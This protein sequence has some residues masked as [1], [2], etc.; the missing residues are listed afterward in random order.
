MKREAGKPDRVAFS[1]HNSCYCQLPLVLLNLQTSMVDLTS[2]VSRLTFAGLSVF[3]RRSSVI[4]ACMLCL[5]SSAHS[6]EITITLPG[7]ET[8]EMVWI[9]PGTFRMGSPSSEPGR[10]ED[11]GPFHERFIS[12]GFYLGKYEVT[13]A[14]W[15]S[16]MEW[17]PWLGKD[18]KYVKEGPEIPA[19]CISWTDAQQFVD[20]MNAAEGRE[21]YRLPNE[22]E[23]E[24]A[25][26]AGTT[27]RWSFGEN[28]GLLKQHAWYFTPPDRPG[29]DRAQKVGMKRPNPWKLYDTHGNVWE[30]VQDKYG[31]NLTRIR[32]DST[33]PDTH[34]YRVLRGGAFS[35]LASSTRSASRYGY[36]PLGRISSVGFRILKEAE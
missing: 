18:E 22:A 9:A 21:V 1:M 32:A 27:T 4:L 16:V 36:D 14:Q 25:S 28:E 10:R 6:K 35:T 20:R 7:G 12:K 23:W 15:I 19:V 2:H 33:A 8:M 5:A 29:K 30:W 31:P 26:R 34:A 17:R 11:E 3:K 13:Q 24:Y